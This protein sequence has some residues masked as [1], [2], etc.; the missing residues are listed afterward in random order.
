MRSNPSDLIL[1]IDDDPDTGQLVSAMLSKSDYQVETAFD[2]AQGL[3]LTRQLHPSLVVLDVMMPGMD[4][5]E[6]YKNVKAISNTPVLFLSALNDIESIAH[7]FD[8]GAA[9]YIVKPF[10]PTDLRFRVS[11]ALEQT[12]SPDDL[13]PEA[14]TKIEDDGQ[15]IPHLSP[16]YRVV[17]RA[18]DIIISSAALLA[19]SPILLL[20]ALLIKLESP[21]PVIYSQKRLGLNTES[22]PGSGSRKL[23][24]FNFYKLRTMVVEA[25]PDLHLAYVDAYIRN[26]K[27]ELANIQGQDSS[28]RK[29]LND[30][31][32]TRVGK[33]LRRSSL[34]EVPQ[35][36]NVIKGDM[37]LVGPRPAL[38]YEVEMYQP[39]HRKRLAAKPGVTGLW[40]VTS[41]SS[42]EF[43]EMVRMDLWYL[44][45]QSLRLDLEI[46]LKTPKAVFSL[47]G[48]F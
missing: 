14:K 27:T 33:F 37:S 3:D 4:G 9:D 42:A 30:P 19:L 26:D 29:L 23:R 8:L 38:A 31:R 44:E 35:L 2:G 36:W 43:D 21:G 39:W 22:E 48:A 46:L 6:T 5:W 16:I 34:D 11:Q 47:S 10:L 12:Q 40:Q 28:S 13:Q 20:S 41:R 32:V 7:G 1:V 25:K 18:L 45:H 24:E 17:K 15:D